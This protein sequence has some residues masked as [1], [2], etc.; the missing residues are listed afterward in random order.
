M[1]VDLTKSSIV[2]NKN[3]NVVHQTKVQ[4]MQKATQLDPRLSSKQ[5]YYSDLMWWQQHAVGFQ[6]HG[7]LASMNKIKAR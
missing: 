5:N 3:S 1:N 7:I 4:G 6:I 2:M